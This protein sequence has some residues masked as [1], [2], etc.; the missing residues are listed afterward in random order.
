VP[1]T[2]TLNNIPDDV[3][4]RLRAYADAHRRLNSEA[5]VCRETALNPGQLTA[6]ERLDRIGRL[7]KNREKT[8]ICSTR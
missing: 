2:L 4:Q 5:I 8:L 3:Y 7:L 6:E 1:A